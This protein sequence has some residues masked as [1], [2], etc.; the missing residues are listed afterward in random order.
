[1]VMRDKDRLREACFGTTCVLCYAYD[2]FNVD[3]L[4]W[5]H[6]TEQVRVGAGDIVCGSDNKHTTDDSHRY[7][8]ITLEQQSA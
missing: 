2:N 5:R 7:R 3:R 6:R 8:Y 1:M 4:S